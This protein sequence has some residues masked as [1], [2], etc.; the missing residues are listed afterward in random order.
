M[1]SENAI[2]VLLVD[3]DRD[4]ANRLA[5]SFTR[6]NPE[7][8]VQPVGTVAAAL[9]V[10]DRDTSGGRGWDAILCT[11]GK[12]HPEGIEFLRRLTETSCPLPVLLIGEREDME[13]A[14]EG[15]KLGASDF[16]LRGPHL[17]R[18]VAPRLRQAVDR[19]RTRSRREL[20]LP[21]L[22]NLPHPVLVADAEG[23]ILAASRA[24]GAVFAKGEEDL[25]GQPFELLFD[26]G[27]GGQL[28]QE[29]LEL[30]SG[31]TLEREVMARRPDGTLFA[32]L[33]TVV[34]PQGERSPLV[35]SLR[36]FSRWREL[37]ES[38][39]QREKLSAIGEL[40]SGV[41]HELNNPLTSVLG[42]SQLLMGRSDCPEKMRRD[43][44]T[45]FEQ[46]HRCERIVQN[47][48]SF[49]RK[50]RPEKKL[51]GVNGVLDSTVALMGYQLRV[52]NI[53]V[54]KELEPDLP[55]TMADYHQLEQVFLNLITN[56]HQAMVMSKK[57]GRLVL[58][59]RSGEG[60]LRVQIID[61]G[62]GIPEDVLPHIFDPFF[63]TKPKGVGTGLGLSLCYGIVSEHGGRIR[64]SSQAGEG[65]T[66]SVELPIRG[67]EEKPE[68]ESDA[69]EEERPSAARRSVLVA[70]DEATIVELLFRVLTAE[71]HR[72]DT[73]RSGD[74]ALRK[75]ESQKY[76]LLI[77]DLKMPGCNGREIFER[78]RSLYPE[79]ARRV[80]IT[81]GDTAGSD[82]RQFLE[83]TGVR[84][85]EKPFNIDDV[86]RLIR[87]L[88]S[89][90][91]A[92]PPAGEPELAGAVSGAGGHEI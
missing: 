81:T 66:F 63:T 3:V 77:T 16:L 87:A 74:V 57:G 4:A 73:A 47:L 48:L 53:Q 45:V 34:R 11:A 21:A 69:R 85:V 43:L 27:S 23:R 44:H 22:D 40:V 59:T 65:A 51:V 9:D 37:Q 62:P 89:E 75:I 15:I 35:L 72:V 12:R 8:H 19:G 33:V 71:G 17:V 86:Q 41:A 67:A 78:W 58:R 83:R 60:W 30:P 2:R 56:A 5:R 28:R 29:A 90:P 39:L 70:D 84:H 24:C 82:T 80:L 76:D 18:N 61:D 50:N 7:L 88:L 31:G 32:A 91:E 25:A 52:D 42:F 92:V 54:V 14:V 38:L 46:A 79:R 64:A 6:S 68:P 10:L 49:A 36:D 55:K 20:L 26:E 13:E 1:P